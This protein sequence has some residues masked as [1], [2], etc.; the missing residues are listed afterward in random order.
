MNTEELQKIV[1][2]YHAHCQDGFGAALAAYTKFKDTASYIACSDRLIPPAGITGKEV[3]ILDF[4]YPQE[5]LQ[6]LRH[7]TAKLV[8]IDH[9]ISAKE[10]VTSVAEHI[11]S[12]EHSGAYLAWEYFVGTKIPRLITFLEII[13]LAS[14]KEGEH[15][16]LTTYILSKPYDFKVYQALL[17][18]FEDE[19]RLPYLKNLGKAQSDYLSLLLDAIIEEPDFVDFEGYTIPCINASLPLNEKSIALTKLYTKYPPFSMSYRFDNELI[20]V[21][22]RGNGDVD[23]SVIAQKYGGGGHRNASGFVLPGTIPLSFVKKITR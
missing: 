18:E 5:V 20:K 7:S 16:D 4:S 21:S 11:Y 14:D 12:E 23:L 1:V 2:I 17:E 8:I 15:R 19:A 13:D 9:H 10:A 22:L 6:E 3:Y